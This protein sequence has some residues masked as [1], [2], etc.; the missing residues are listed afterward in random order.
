MENNASN[1]KVKKRG[2]VK[3]VLLIILGAIIGINLISLLINQVIFRNE[4]RGIEPP[5]Q[6]V[7]V[8]GSMM[9]VHSMGD[10]GVYEIR[11]GVSNRILEL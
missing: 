8:N 3:M 1:M 10:D 9:H 5:G 11:G 2:R 6:L 4:L 7:E